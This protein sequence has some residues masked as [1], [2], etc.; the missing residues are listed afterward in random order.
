[1][2][3]A[4]HIA[5]VR[6]QDFF[7]DTRTSCQTRRIVPHLRLTDMAP[8]VLHLWMKLSGRW[9]EAAGF[10]PD[11]RLRIEVTHKR[12]VITPIDDEDSAHFGNDGSPDVDSA[13]GPQR[14]RFSVIAGDAQ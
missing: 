5:P 13:T 11:Q 12:L 3:D 4:N 2:A 10:E 6:F 7:V 9:I 1:M 14:R 8:P